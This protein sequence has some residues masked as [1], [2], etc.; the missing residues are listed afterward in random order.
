MSSIRILMFIV[1]FMSFIT[2]VSAQEFGESP[3]LQA[4]IE[5]TRSESAEI[6]RHAVEILG[7][8]GDSLVVPVLIGA[9]KD[10][11]SEVRECAVLS[12]GK[13]GDTSAVPFLI[14]LLKD[15][16][17]SIRKNVV[18]IL[19]DTGDTSLIPILANVLK[20][21]R[22]VAVKVNAAFALANMGGSAIPSLIKML[23]GSTKIFAAMAI[24]K[25]LEKTPDVSLIPVLL[26]GL[27]D[28]DR[29]VRRYI[30]GAL[31]KLGNPAVDALVD[32][33]NNRRKSENERKYAAEALGDIG[34]TSAIPVL[35]GAIED[36]SEEI[37]IYAAQALQKMGKAAV[38]QA[39]KRMV[40]KVSDFDARL[41]NAFFLA[42]FSDEKSL[43]F[44]IKILNYETYR[45]QATQA[46]EKYYGGKVRKE[47]AVKKIP[48][49]VCGGSGFCP[50]CG[51]SGKI[52]SAT[53]F[54]FDCDWCGGTGICPVCRGEGYILRVFH[55]YI[56][57]PPPV[58]DVNVGMPVIE[59]EE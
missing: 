12:L 47:D 33:L 16:N 56:Y 19:G 43:Q 3:S 11:S 30:A 13:L 49:P 17:P 31:K 40:E 5:S 21:D 57:L 18:S 2:G 38:E 34:D 59:T 9:L 41:K 28:R 27:N 1:I 32:S 7:E 4:L 29:D 24:G 51:G 55:R 37:K 58:G 54:I 35:V 8:T 36:G 23:Q 52:S 53:F 14:E 44:L 20:K 15:K 10:K 39:G 6:R 48:C 45:R 25:A 22:N 42:K 46:L 26:K 50:G